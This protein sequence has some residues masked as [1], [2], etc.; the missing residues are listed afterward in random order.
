MKAEVEAILRLQSLDLR[1]ADLEKEIQALPKHVS[2]IERKLD[3]FLRRLEADRASLSAN[4]RERKSLEDDIKAQQGKISKLRDQMMQA[5]TNEQYRAFQNEIAFAEGEISKSED[6]ILDL[7][8]AAEP[9]ETAVKR[10]E[11][12]LAERKK[13]VEAEQERARK[14]TAEDQAFL[15]KARQERSQLTAEVNPQLLR[16]YEQ[17]RKRGRGLAVSD[18]TNGTCEACHIALRPQYFQELRKGEK[19]LNCETCGRILYYKPPVT[20]EHELHQR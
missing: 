17:I 11:S 15:E 5:K 3:A 10:A 18:A 16:Q 12:A 9:M 19:L 1:I 4:A 6:K 13:E 7:M 20:V 14:R 8:A 2:E